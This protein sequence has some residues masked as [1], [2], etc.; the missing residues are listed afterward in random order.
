MPLPPGAVAR[1]QAAIGCF[2]SQL[3]PRAAAGPVLSAD[4]VTHFT[5]DFEVLF[6]VRRP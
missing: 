5:R 2:A 1:K 4:F 3:E 6:P